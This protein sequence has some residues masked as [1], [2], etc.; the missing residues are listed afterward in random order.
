MGSFV[1]N[2]LDFR[3]RQTNK[4][5]ISSIFAFGGPAPGSNVSENEYQQKYAQPFV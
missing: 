1:C 3:T 5:R 2:L 4:W